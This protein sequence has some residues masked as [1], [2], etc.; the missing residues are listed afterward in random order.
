MTSLFCPTSSDDV[1]HDKALSSRLAAL[2]E[3]DLGLEHLGVDV[4]KASFEVETV[5]AACG[6]SAF[7]AIIAASHTHPRIVLATLPACQSPADKSAI[8]VAAH[9]VVVGGTSLS[10]R[11]CTI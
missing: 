8:L 3:T 10:L 1:S 9:K 2:N 4:G 7:I 5:V 6:Q 11:L